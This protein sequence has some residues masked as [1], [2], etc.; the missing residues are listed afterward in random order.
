MTKSRGVHLTMNEFI[1]N[2]FPPLRIMVHKLFND[3]K[4]KEKWMHT[5]CNLENELAA[6]YNNY[7]LE[8]QP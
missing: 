6:K 1:N 7:M 3:E 2:T 4:E 8:Q 5:L